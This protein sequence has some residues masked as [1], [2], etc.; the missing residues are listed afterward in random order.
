MPQAMF[1][2][3]PREPEGKS[4]AAARRAGPKGRVL[5]TDISPAILAYAAQSAAQA[6]L[7][8]ET[9]E[10]DG[11]DLDTLRPGSFDAVISRLGLIYF[12][13]QQRA[14]S[15]MA[16][17]LRDG[18]RIARDRLFDGGTQRVLFAA[19]THHP[20]ARPSSPRLRRGS[21]G[22]SAWAHPACCRPPWSAPGSAT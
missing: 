16:R 22:R 21:R 14:L 8:I 12:P 13:D 6:G 7:H 10:L 17:A 9:L 19:G 20:R 18:G 2:T 15:G 1:S 5:A 11:E 4:L 3:L